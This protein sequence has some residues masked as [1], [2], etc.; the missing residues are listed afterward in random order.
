VDYK[1][2]IKQKDIKYNMTREQ[3]DDI[4]CEIMINWGPDS[5]I[6]GHENITD[7]IM[8]LLDKYEIKLLE[9]IM[10]EQ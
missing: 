7:F 10:K 3:I 1:E 8:R 9:K 6:D 4:I 5:H 2:W